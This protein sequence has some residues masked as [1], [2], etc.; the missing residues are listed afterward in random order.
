MQLILHRGNDEPLGDLLDGIDKAHPHRVAA[1]PCRHL[2]RSPAHQPHDHTASS[3][4]HDQAR[5]HRESVPPHCGKGRHLQICQDQIDEKPSQAHDHHDD[6]EPLQHTNDLA[7]PESLTHAQIGGGN[8]PVNLIGQIV[9]MRSRCT[10]HRL[11]PALRQA[12]ADV[13]GHGTQGIVDLG[14]GHPG[15]RRQCGTLH[16]DRLD[17]FPGC[18]RRPA[19]PPI[20]AAARRE[21]QPAQWVRTQLHQPG[22]DRPPGGS[23]SPAPS[24]IGDGIDDHVNTASQAQGVQQL[25]GL[26]TRHGRGTAIADLTTHLLGH[27]RDVGL[28][29]VRHCSPARH[30]LGKVL[31]QLI[32][33]FPGHRGHRQ[34]LGFDQPLVVQDAAQVTNA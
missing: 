26:P 30:R 2:H 20:R 31:A 19:P 24:G 32:H 11:R 17:V 5:G 27:P 4:C 28:E 12:K 8:R 23:D 7:P 22:H 34:D 6:E 18:P 16:V 10:A 15:S 21:V 9:A 3:S 14:R 33:A 13:V 25:V 1:M 29:P